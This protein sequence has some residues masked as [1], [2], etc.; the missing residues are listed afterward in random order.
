[1]EGDQIMVDILLCLTKFHWYGYVI[2]CVRVCCG[3]WFFKIFSLDV[4]F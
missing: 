4:N 2:L 3:G 1:M